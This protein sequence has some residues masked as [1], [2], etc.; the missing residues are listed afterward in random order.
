MNYSVVIPLY[1]KE[2]SIVKTVKSVLNQEYAQFEIVVVNDGSTDKSLERLSQIQDDR[3]RIISTENGGV[4]HARNVGIREAKYEWIAFLDGDDIWEKNYLHEMVLFMEKYSDAQMYGANRYIINKSG[5]IVRKKCRLNADFMGY[6]LPYYKYASSMGPLFFLSSTIVNKEKSIEIGLFDE[7]LSFGED[8]DFIIRF[9]FY[10]KVAF[11]NR[12]LIYYRNDSENRAME[13]V[14]PFK[15]TIQY[16]VLEGKYDE[17]ASEDS[18][19][20]KY[21]NGL[22]LRYLMIPILDKYKLD[23]KIIDKYI[24]RTRTSDIGLKKYILYIPYPIIKFLVSFII[25]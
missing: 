12:Y 22:A 14:H 11:Y 15:K 1:N 6:L 4:S 9:T 8:M 24:K 21:I 25:K 2:D 17:F 16:Q 10:N 20:N 5:D 23:K 18:I 13:R 7:T 19:F 3:I